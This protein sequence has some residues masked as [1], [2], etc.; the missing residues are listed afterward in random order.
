MTRSARRAAPGRRLLLLA[1]LL[2][3]AV[4]MLPPGRPAEPHAMED[5]S[6]GRCVASAR[7]PGAA[8]RGGAHHTPGAPPQVF[9]ADNPGLWMTHCHNV[10]QSESRMMTVIG[11]QL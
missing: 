2:L 3:G 5:V 7:S 11:Y 1:A 9:G 8:A 10:H 6:P 4:T